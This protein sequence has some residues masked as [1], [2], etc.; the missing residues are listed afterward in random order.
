MS[1]CLKKRVRM[2]PESAA[3]EQPPQLVTEVVGYR[4]KKV[5]LTLQGLASASIGRSVL[6]SARIVGHRTMAPLLRK[7]LSK[8]GRTSF[9]APS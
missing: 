9:V 3:V 7:L 5:G 4:G 1:H 8:Y 6:V 2:R